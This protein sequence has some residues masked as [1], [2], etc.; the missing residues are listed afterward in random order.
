MHRKTTPKLG[1]H[2]LRRIHKVYNF[3]L[4]KDTPVNKVTGTL[5]P[6]KKAAHELVPIENSDELPF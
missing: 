6:T 1:K 5:P 3:D 2:F 4:S